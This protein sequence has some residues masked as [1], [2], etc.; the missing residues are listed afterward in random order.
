VLATVVFISGA[1]LAPASK[2]AE[3][4]CATNWGGFASDTS[5]KD[6]FPSG[7]YP[8]PASCW[9]VLIKGEIV[10]GDRAKFEKL[11]RQNH[12][13]V[14]EV[15]LW[16]PG[17]LVDEAMKIGSL[18]RKAMLITRA[19]DA[20]SWKVDSNGKLNTFGFEKTICQGVDCNCASA[21]ALIWAAGI[22][23]M[24]ERI[25]LHRPSLRSTNF[26]NLPPDRASV[27]Y[28]LLLSDIDRY[29]TAMEVPRTFVDAMIDTSSSDIQWIDP[30]MPRRMEIVPSIAEWINASCGDNYLARLHRYSKENLDNDRLRKE[31]DAEDALI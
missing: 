28:R 3:I 9:E 13:F 29:L 15:H 18:V 31:L 25:G 7:R 12:P 27:L 21:C 6:H 23:R 16:S 2:A 10:A 22:K 1:F 19:P 14:A 5:F 4:I 20:F 17:G 8:N 24:G 11:L 30:E 26:A